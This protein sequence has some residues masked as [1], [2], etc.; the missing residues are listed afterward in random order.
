MQTGILLIKCLIAAVLDACRMALEDKGRIFR[1]GEA[2]TP[3]VSIPSAVAT[4]SAF[5]F[6]DGETVTVSIE[7][8]Q[9]RIMALAGEGPTRTP[10]RDRPQPI[11]RHTQ[12]C[13]CRTVCAKRSPRIDF[14]LW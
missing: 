12:S 4:D 3:Y 2:N 11:P 14:R 10:H 9:L 1:S 7:D 5:P 8:D 6:E 13:Q